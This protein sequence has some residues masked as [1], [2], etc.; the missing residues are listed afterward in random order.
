MCVCSRAYIFPFVIHEEK[1]TAFCVSVAESHR[2]VSGCGHM[3]IFCCVRLD[4]FWVAQHC[5]QQYILVV[6]SG[7]RERLQSDWPRCGDRYYR[8]TILKIIISA[9]FVSMKWF[10]SNSSLCSPLLYF[11]QKES[12]SPVSSAAVVLMTL[13]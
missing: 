6:V 10:V 11:E 1:A 5:R 13:N 4:G 9:I 12:K 3:G 2:R 7:E 8:F